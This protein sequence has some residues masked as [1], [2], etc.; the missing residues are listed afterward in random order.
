M[1]GVSQTLPAG[2][3]VLIPPLVEQSM[4]NIGEWSSLVLYNYVYR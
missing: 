3:V 2:S 1:N 4:Q